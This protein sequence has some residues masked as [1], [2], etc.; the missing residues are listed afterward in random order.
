M[1]QIN[2]LSIQQTPPEKL[3]N[4]YSPSVDSN[5]DTDKV[6]IAGKNEENYS[7]PELIMKLSSN[8]GGKN[9]NTHQDQMPVAKDPIEVNKDSK[10]SLHVN[11][12]S[13]VLKGSS[14]DGKVNIN[15]ND[16]GLTLKYGGFEKRF[17]KKD[18]SAKKII[19]DLGKGN[20][21]LFADPNVKYDLNIRAG[22]GNNN[23][24][25]GKGA[26][27]IQLGDGNNTIYAGK[28]DDI[29]SVG[30][31][32]NEIYGGAGDDTIYVKG[33]GK[34]K[35]FGNSGNDYIQGG[36]GND[37][38]HGG[39]GD[40]IIYGLDGDDF[41][42]GGTGNDYLDGG[43]G[44]D[45]LKGGAGKDILSGGKGNDKLYGGLGADILIDDKAIANART[46][47]KVYINSKDTN[48][49]ESIKI[50]GDNTFKSRV[51]S[52][53]ETLRAL[54]SGTK[55]LEELD[56]TGKTTTIK[57]DFYSSALPSDFE[58]GTIKPDGTP[59]LGTN[60]TI[61]YNPE[62]P[63]T[64]RST[65][66][67]PPIGTLF[68]EMAHAYNLKTGTF[69]GEYVR[70]IGENTDKVEKA[71]EHQAIGLPIGNLFHY[72]TELYIETGEETGP[73]SSLPPIKHP[74]GTISY[75]NPKGIS[76]NDI[77]SD[78]NITPRTEY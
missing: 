61:T 10:F 25:T 1:N 57:K 13:I 58:K 63:L 73:D 59:N 50:K 14:G 8:S 42:I 27:N 3:T 15:Q 55:M 67:L 30:S 20:N 31:G 38:I 2:G 11:G 78:L 60:T 51:E 46:G 64:E 6:S 76:E 74:D 68:H 16:E 53:L 21:F 18:A 69:I 72:D 44:N 24:T 26:D 49:G 41:I 66:S 12:S 40:D 71:S 47:D 5:L 48:L 56:K 29:I 43:N 4:K 19:I 9:I 32:N 62:K 17:T 22:S 65:D 70:D 52:D 45:I 34:N 36:S 33:D 75:N 37:Y 77:R 7:N 28:G 39:S 23:V 35:I 54:P